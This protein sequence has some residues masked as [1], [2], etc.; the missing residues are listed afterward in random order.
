MFGRQDGSGAR[1]GGRRTR[2]RDEV[3]RLDQQVIAW[4][5][6]AYPSIAR[7]ALFLVYFWFGL[8]KLIGLSEATPL[9]RALTAKTIGLAHFQVM[10]TALA[11]FECLIGVLCL[12]PRATRVVVV[13][14]LVHLAMVCAPEVLVRNLTWQTTLVPTMDGQYIIKNVLIVAAA[15]GLLSRTAPLPVTVPGVLPAIAD[16]VMAE[17]VIVA[18]VPRIDAMAVIHRHRPRHIVHRTRKVGVRSQA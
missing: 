17:P 2:W 1:P 18:A 8:V 3:R 12:I 7:V 11:L 6:L 4:A 5:D 13:M 9:A 15:V 14:L 10:F 16:T